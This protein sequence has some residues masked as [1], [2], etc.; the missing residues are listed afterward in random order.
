MRRASFFVFAMVAALG[1]AC[2]TAPAVSTG[3]SDDT[4]R[5]AGTMAADVDGAGAI[6]TGPAAPPEAGSEAGD[7]AFLYPPDSAAPPADAASGA[8][9]D[10]A[11]AAPAC[12]RVGPSKSC[13]VA[14]QCG[15]SSNETCD[16]DGTGDSSCVGPAGLGVPGNHC[17]NAAACEVGLTCAYGQSC[18]PFCTTAGQACSGTNLGKCIQL[19]GAGNVAIP[20]FL[21]CEIKCQLQDPSTC[22]FGS[23]CFESSVTPGASDCYAAGAKGY[24]QVCVY[25]DDCQAGYGCVG[26]SGG[27]YH[28]KKW[29]RV[30]QNADCGGSTCTGFSPALVVNNVTYGTCP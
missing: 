29:C 26:V 20:N 3:F 18:R 5:E 12:N 4:S 7:A 22:G 17:V 14:P 13:G 21:V 6:D 11:D 23:G 25:A 19:N 15:C 9:A 16:L 30:G 1:G 2:A 24:N 8:D 10:A 27:T 28:C